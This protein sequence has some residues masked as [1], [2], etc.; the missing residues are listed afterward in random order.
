MALTTIQ[1]PFRSW[2]VF[3]SDKIPRTLTEYKRSAGLSTASWARLWGHTHTQPE[4]KWMGTVDTPNDILTSVSSNQH[5]PL[6]AILQIDNQQNVNIEDYIIIVHKMV[7]SFDSKETGKNRKE[8]Y[9][10]VGLVQNLLFSNSSVNIWGKLTFTSTCFFTKSSD[11]RHLISETV[12]NGS[13]AFFFW[14]YGLCPS[15]CWEYHEHPISLI[16]NGCFPSR[17]FLDARHIREEKVGAKN[18]K[19]HIKDR[20]RTVTLESVSSSSPVLVHFFHK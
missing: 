19:T 20:K 7:F 6:T 14:T 17:D 3:C 10:R 9:I 16:H 15:T 4:H 8:R 1:G 11:T 18:L 13:K 12:Y 2:R 5:K